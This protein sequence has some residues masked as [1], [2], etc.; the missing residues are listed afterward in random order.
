MHLS[1]RVEFKAIESRLLLDVVP[2]FKLTDAWFSKLR[3][4]LVCA[5]VERDNFVSVVWALLR[6]G[7]DPCEVLHIPWVILSRVILDTAHC[8]SKSEVL[9]MQIYLK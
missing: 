5:L 7:I 3:P 8:K 4:V 6:V 1:L 9:L 2:K